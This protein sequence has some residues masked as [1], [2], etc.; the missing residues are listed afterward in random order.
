[1]RG[2]VNRRGRAIVA[3]EFASSRYWRR[4]PGGTGDPASCESRHTWFSARR[5]MFL[6]VVKPVFVALGGKLSSLKTTIEISLSSLWGHFVPFYNS[7]RYSL[8]Y[9]FQK[10]ARNFSISWYVFLMLRSMR[11]GYAGSGGRPIGKCPRV[12]EK[13]RW[14]NMINK[15]GREVRTASTCA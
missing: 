4:H 6:V 12:T 13:R 2:R 9:L 3:F 1:M 11:A 8:W 10:F 5:S 7:E 15:G 14:V